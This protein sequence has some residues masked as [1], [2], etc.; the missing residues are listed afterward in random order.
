MKIFGQIVAILPLALI[1]SLP[2]QLFAH[3]PIT[4]ISSQFTEYLERAEEEALVSESDEEEE[5]TQPTKD[6]IPELGDLFRVGQYVRA[7]VSNVH[8]PGAT[9][10]SGIGRSRDD[11]TKASKRVELSLLPE[12]V[13]SGVQKSDLKS[14]FVRVHLELAWINTDVDFPVDLDGSC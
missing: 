13:N 12:R 7:V 3:V 4:N 9:D 10:V 1:I 11:I 5:E 2:N 14:G 8:A 6:P